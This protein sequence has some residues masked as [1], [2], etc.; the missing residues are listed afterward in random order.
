MNVLV[1][2]NV[3]VNHCNML[4][5]L[6]GVTLGVHH[7]LADRLSCCWFGRQLS[8]PA[9][10]CDSM[11]TILLAFLALS[12]TWARSDESRSCAKHN[13]WLMVKLVNGRNICKHVGKPSIS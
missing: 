4:S 3:T 9:V 13:E 7:S 6:F 12:G 5:L 2:N 8:Q 10:V 11:S 1:M